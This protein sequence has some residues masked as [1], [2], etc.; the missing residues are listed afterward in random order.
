L[1]LGV[2]GQRAKTLG[3][4]KNQSKQNKEEGKKGKQHMQC[5]T[6]DAI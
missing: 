2:P 5:E 4:Q 1:F 3:G 6:L